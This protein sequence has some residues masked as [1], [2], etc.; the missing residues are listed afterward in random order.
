MYLS[1]ESFWVMLCKQVSNNNPML[2]WS[3]ALPI[4]EEVADFA[5]GLDDI[6]YGRQAHDLDG[7]LPTM[8]FSIEVVRVHQEPSATSGGD[9]KPRYSQ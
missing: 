7:Q 5:F 2:L 6:L 8:E 3:S 4:V 9:D 1:I